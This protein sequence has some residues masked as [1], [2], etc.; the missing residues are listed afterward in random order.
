MKYPKFTSFVCS[1]E[2]YDELRKCCKENG[3]TLGE[4]I[5]NVLEHDLK[6]KGY[7]KELDKN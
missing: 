4:Y 5:R 3:L 1:N 6:K 7:L 2:F